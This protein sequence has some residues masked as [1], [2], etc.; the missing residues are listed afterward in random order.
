M[1]NNEF[2]KPF[3]KSLMLIACV[4]IVSM[5][6]AHHYIPKFYNTY[7]NSQEYSS[8]KSYNEAKAAQ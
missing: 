7:L 8:Y 6:L 5:I 4:T 1:K 3:L 2:H